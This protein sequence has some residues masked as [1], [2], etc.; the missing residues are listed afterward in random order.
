MVYNTQS[1]PIRMREYGRAIQQMVEQACAIPDRHARQEFAAEIVQTMNKLS[2]E[3]GN[4]QEK[5]AKLWNH[6]AVI[7]EHRLDIDY[8]FDIVREARHGE[9]GTL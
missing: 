9:G 4:S 2:S 8:P 3:K 7:S 6:L 5:Q 1:A